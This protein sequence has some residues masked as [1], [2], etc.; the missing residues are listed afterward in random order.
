[1]VKAKAK[2]KGSDKILTVIFVLA[3]LTGFYLVSMVNASFE[4]DKENISLFNSD[5]AITFGK[6]ANTGFPVNSFANFTTGINQIESTSYFQ[7]EKTP[8]YLGN[9]TWSYSVNATDSYTQA[10]YVIE[11]PNME[12][13]IID[14]IV[15]NQSKNTDTDLRQQITIWSIDST[16]FEYGTIGTLLYS[17][18][19]IGGTTLYHNH[20]VDLSLS[21]ALDVLDKASDN[22]K[23][24]ITISMD[25][26]SLDGLGAFSWDFSIEISG[27]QIDS[28]NITQQLNLVMGIAITINVLCIVF[29]SDEIDIGG[30][31]ND[32]PNKKRR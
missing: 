5:S 26:T 27:K 8:V 22:T 6:Y 16:N 29:M 14:E 11:L 31:I 32:I 12:N 17:D 1:M 9:E 19:G 7:Y 18:S 20:T 24:F 15:I 25:D 10:L 28:Y 2:N 4:N 21:Q 30:F 23:H 3:I 13:W